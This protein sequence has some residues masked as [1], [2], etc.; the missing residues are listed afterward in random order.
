ME[1]VAPRAG[2]PEVRFRNEPTPGE[3]ELRRLALD[4]GA[5]V[6]INHHPHVL[7]GFEAYDGKL[8]AHSLGNFVFDLYYPETM[9]TL[10]LTI[11][12]EKHG[13]TGYRFTPAWI[14]HW[15]P[16]PAV[17]DLG[18]A[19]IQRLADDS[20]PMNALVVP[21]AGTNEARIHLS[22]AEVDSIVTDHEATLPPRERRQ[23]RRLR[24]A[25]EVVK[26]GNLSGIASLVGDGTW[27]VRWGREIL[28][29]GGFEDEGADLW[30]VN[31]ADE[32]LDS[33]VAHSGR[34]SLRLRR[35][36]SASGQTGTDLEKNLP[37]DPGQGAFGGGLATHRERRPGPHHGPLLQQPLFELAPV[38]YRSG[39]ASRRVQR[40]ETAVAGSGHAVEC[41]LLR[42]ALRTRTADQWYRLQLV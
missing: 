41:H 3:R 34:R 31:T 37:C 35:L 30:E 1:A 25:G 40:L 23:P 38:R 42:H 28:W 16:E 21:I 4:Y 33:E 18:R 8:I 14:N 36:S 2:D 29:H 27:E 24:A 15:I 9:P 5:D 10:V 26:D 19:I 13:I 22:R 39:P 11:E 32:V 7:Q 20:R 17:G 6:L 12:I